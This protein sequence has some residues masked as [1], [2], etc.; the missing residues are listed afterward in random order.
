MFYRLRNYLHYAHFRRCTRGI[1][2][3]PPTPC[4]PDAACEVHTM[5]SRHD[6]SLYLLAA[7]SFLRFHPD[8]AVVI[9]D[10]GS[11]DR[12]ALDT[13]QRHVPGCRIVHAAEADRRAEQALL[14]YPFLA[15]WRNVDCCWRRLIDTELGSRT[16]KRIIM[17]SDVLTLRP[18]EEVM[19]WINEEEK[20]FL[21]GQPSAKPFVFTEQTVPNTTHVQNKFRAHLAK[22]ASALDLPADFEDGTTAGFYGCGPDHLALPMVERLLKTTVELKLPMH[23]WGADQC[24]VI[25][26]LSATGVLRLSSERYFN[27]CPEVKDR[28]ST[29]AFVHFYG[30]NRFYDKRYPQLASRVVSELREKSCLV[31][32]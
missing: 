10:D 3:T 21:M 26:L 25:Y 18:L 27:F 1:H 28:L 20:P 14:P 7:K 24:T 6:L 29:A 15:R 11:L 9:H 19:A 22:I 16:D 13:V 23:Q 4:R 31:P 5:L 30:T 2:G 32:S 12:A 8:V 17:D